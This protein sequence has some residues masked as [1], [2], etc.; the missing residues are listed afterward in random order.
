MY[1]SRFRAVDLKALFREAL[2]LR[3]CLRGTIAVEGHGPKA[4]SKA[5]AVELGNHL[6]FLMGAKG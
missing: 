2:A 5:T 4:M 6:V 3:G 1:D